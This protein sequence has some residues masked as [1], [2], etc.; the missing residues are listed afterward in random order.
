MIDENF[1]DRPTIDIGRFPNHRDTPLLEEL[2]EALCG[3]QPTNI[4][5]LSGIEALNANAL[6][7]IGKGVAVDQVDLRRIQH[8][9][10]LGQ[11]ST[12]IITR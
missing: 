11:K 8:L 3:L 12:G 6:Y 7:A 1:S 5:T 10:S 4:S 9:L 2:L